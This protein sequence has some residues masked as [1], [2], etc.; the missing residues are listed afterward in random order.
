MGKSSVFFHYQ[1][2]DINTYFERLYMKKIELKL[3]KGDLIVH[4]V[5]GIGTVKGISTKKIQGE[6]HV[7]YKIKTDRL[8]YWLPVVNSNSDRI[9]SVRAPSTFTSAI[10]IIRQ[11]PQ[12]LFNNFRSRLKYINEELAKCSLI[13]NARLIRDLHA[14]NLVKRLHVN[15]NRTYEKI[16]EHFI[17]EWAVSANISKAEA[18]KRMN[19]A[20]LTSGRKHSENS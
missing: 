14:R 16:K 12:K 13:A 7:F 2:P 3:S 5:H 8:T 11:K 9:R 18:G 19:D 6:Q 17:N 20:L 15:E 4:S 1:H 10:S